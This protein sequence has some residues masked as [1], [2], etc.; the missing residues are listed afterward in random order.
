MELPLALRQAIETVLTGRRPAELERAASVLSDRYRREVRDGRLHL[1]D[2]EAAAAYL[3]TRL[4]AT[5]AAIRAA[6]ASVAE[7]RPAF[8]PLRLLDV[9]AGPGTAMWAAADCWPGLGHAVLLEASGAIRK[10]GMAL[11]RDAATA[12]IDWLEADATAPLP[13]AA[14]PAHLVTLAYVL[15]ELPEAAGLTLIDRLWEH[16]TGVLLLVEPG[17]PN[18]W[19]R[20]MA[21]R[22]RLLRQ[23]ASIVAPCP[24]ALACPLAAPDWCHFSRRLARSRLHRLAKGGEVPWEDERFAYLAVAR[25][26]GALPAARILAPPRAASGR[27]ALKLCGSDGK[28]QDRLVTKRD[29]EAYRIARR[30]DWGDAL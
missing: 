2:G 25:E 27:I 1:V 20:L 14:L 5:Y 9:G 21:A 3:A 8:A 23:G 18:G 13:A 22:D 15:N 7:Q 11:A 6:M 29:T 24:H 30:A 4:P 10:A 26:P 17:T 28:A 12:R 16:T 19:R